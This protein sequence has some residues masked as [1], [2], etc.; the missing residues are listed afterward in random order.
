MIPAP[1][2][3][4]PQP[5]RGVLVAAVLLVLLGFALFATGMIAGLRSDG[6]ARDAMVLGCAA[7]QVATA[8]FLCTLAGGL[9]LKRL[10]K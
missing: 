5:G 1:T 6:P 10:V 9:W 3:P 7:W 4:P 8:G 2:T